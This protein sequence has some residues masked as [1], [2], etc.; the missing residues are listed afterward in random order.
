MKF[1]VNRSKMY[2]CLVIL[3]FFG[4][5]AGS[6]YLFYQVLSLPFLQGIDEEALRT[7]V[8]LAWV[9]I[10]PAWMALFFAAMALLETFLP[11]PDS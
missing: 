7:V 2:Q 5:G 6:I 4:S 10:I 3:F 11:R 9:M 8:S 1:I